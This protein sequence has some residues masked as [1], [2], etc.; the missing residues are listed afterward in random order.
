MKK[1]VS[2]Y[3]LVLGYL[4]IFLMFIGLILLVPLLVLFG[5]RSN[6][7]MMDNN[8]S[9]LSQAECFFIPGLASIVVGFLLFLLIM[10]KQKAKLQDMEDIILT[11]LVWLLAIVL[12]A[13]PF[14]MT[15]KFNFTQAIFETTSGYTTTGLSVVDVSKCPHIFL[16]FRSFMQFIGGVG[17]V[18]ILTS[19]ISDRSGMGIYML[20]GHNDRLLPNL[21]KSARLIFAIYFLYVFLGIIL[22]CCLGM[23]FFDALCTSMSALSTG[24]F[25]TQA[26]SIAAYDSIG[27]EAVTVILMLLGST[28]FVIHYFLLRGKFKN[29][30]KHYEFAVLAGMLLILYP[31]I[32]AT[33]GMQYNSAALGFRYGTFEFVSFMTTSGFEA[34][35]GPNGTGYIELPPA[36]LFA[37]IIL[38]CIGGQAGSTSGAMK[39]SRVGIFFLYIYWSIAKLGKNSKVITTHYIYKYGEKEKVDQNEIKNSVSFICLY[40]VILLIG[41]MVI[42]LCGY[43]LDE[44][45]FEF[46]SSLGTV[47]SSVGITSYSANPVVLWTEVIGMFL[48][49]LELM[50]IFTFFAKLNHIHIRRQLK[51]KNQ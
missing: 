1:E 44:S 27:I 51:T 28:N 48:G 37:I 20:E 6:E 30:F 5:Y 35:F 18:L 10:N 38:M 7:Y 12:S 8:M 23:S 15:G 42:C 40:L 14:M 31:I 4:G 43:P 34:Y 46:A 25:S 13:V 29:A 3:K 11:I 32:V 33:I 36:A 9:I 41:T 22:Y 26:K 2:G 24:G 21:I 50:V 49:R 16:F 17:L 45:L 39:Q 47:G 19:A